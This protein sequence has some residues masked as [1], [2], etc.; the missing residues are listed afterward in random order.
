MRSREDLQHDID[1]T[2]RSLHITVSYSSSR[3]AC[4][5]TA[6]NQRRGESKT[7]SDAESLAV[8]NIHVR[9]DYAFW[10]EHVETHDATVGNEVGRPTMP[11]ATNSSSC[12]HTHTAS[13]LKKRK[14]GELI[15]HR[16]FDN[17]D[18]CN[19][20]N[21]LQVCLCGFVNVA[22]CSDQSGWFLG[23]GELCCVLV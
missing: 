7:S 15:L 18:E 3:H 6:S 16:L 20:G 10:R 12:T 21:Y 9:R 23:P 19:A 11:L 4:R 2:D 1:R 14:P 22:G 13:A 17:V 8:F 5:Y